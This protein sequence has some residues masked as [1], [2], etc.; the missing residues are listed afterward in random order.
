MPEKNHLSHEGFANIIGQG[1]E[2]KGDLKLEDGVMIDGV[3]DGTITVTGLLVIGPNA[4][5]KA[6]IK[7]SNIQ[8]YGKV[9]GK[10]TCEGLLSLFHSALI[11]GEI[12]TSLLST[13]EGALLQGKITMKHSHDLKQMKPMAEIDEV[14]E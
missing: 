5:I 4:D 14:E 1:A 11:K 7:A 9:N 8:V 13:E 3:F 12:N 2:I 10:V 6:D